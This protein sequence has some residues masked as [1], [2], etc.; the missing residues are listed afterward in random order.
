MQLSSYSWVNFEVI[1]L[2]FCTAFLSHKRLGKKN[3]FCFYF[4]LFLFPN[5]PDLLLQ[6]TCFSSFF[7]YCY[8]S[9]L[10]S[11]SLSFFF[12]SFYIYIFLS[13]FS[14]SFSSILLSFYIYM[15]ISPSL[16]FFLFLYPF[17]SFLAIPFLRSF[18]G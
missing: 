18:L 13:P 7:L 12:L 8:L 3:I 10:P 11:L 1:H 5:F 17:F 14:L 6:L 4:G 15:F 9:I 2:H 16:S